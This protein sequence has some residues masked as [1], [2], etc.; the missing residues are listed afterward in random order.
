ML[1]HLRPEDGAHIAVEVLDH[2]V[3]VRATGEIDF[4]TAASL[5]RALA[6]ALT[7]ASPAKP[8]AIDCSRVTFCD[9]SALDALLRAR[10]AAQPTGTAIRIAA[11]NRRLQQLLDM[12]GTL[13]LFPVDQDPP[14]GDHLSQ[15]RG[16]GVPR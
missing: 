12:T 13:P 4:D 16:E 9:S 6:E 5:E 10:H 11:S 15:G 2:A 7:H 14:A 8:V 3:V 1:D